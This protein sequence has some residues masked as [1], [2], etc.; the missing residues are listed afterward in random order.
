MNGV[1]AAVL[2]DLN[3]PVF[4]RQLFALPKSHQLAVLR[5]LRR[6]SGMTWDLVHRDSGLRCEAI[7]GRTGKGGERLYTLRVSRGF[8]AVAVRQDDWLRVL[9]LHPDHDSAHER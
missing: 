4:Q 7:L 5:T 8:R 3:C 6:L 9:S 2:L 1:H